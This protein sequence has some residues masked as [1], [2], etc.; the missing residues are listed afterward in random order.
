MDVPQELSLPGR[1]GWTL[2]LTCIW[3]E[4]SR[5]PVPYFI[6]FSYP[7][8]WLH[9]ERTVVVDVKPP[10]LGDWFSPAPDTP[11]AVGREE[12]EGIAEEE[13]GPVACL[14]T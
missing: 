13:G 5:L 12:A 9:L 7:L 8:L 11:V 6:F 2:V 14:C 4:D 1:L 3:R 10:V